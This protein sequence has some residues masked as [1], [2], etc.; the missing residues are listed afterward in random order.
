MKKNK[1]FDELELKDDFMFYLIMGQER[2]CKPFLEIILETEIE[3]LEYHVSQASIEHR[4]LSKGGRLD[5]YV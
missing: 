5:V 4:P 3:K 1:K 2:Y